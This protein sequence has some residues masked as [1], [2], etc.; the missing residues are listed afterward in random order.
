MT[1]SDEIEKTMKIITGRN[2]LMVCDSARRIESGS[3]FLGFTYKWRCYFCDI[4]SVIAAATCRK[5]SGCHF[6][7]GFSARR[8]LESRVAFYGRYD[9]LTSGMQPCRYFTLLGAIFPEQLKVDRTGRSF[10]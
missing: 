7:V 10:L 9:K 3:A 8:C 6:V 2:T 1:R 4:V 5:C